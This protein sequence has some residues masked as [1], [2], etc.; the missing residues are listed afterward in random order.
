M[1][2][3]WETAK[4]IYFHFKLHE[5][6]ALG[7]QLTYYLIL[8]FFP[9]LIFLLT[10]L[11]YTPVTSDLVLSDLARLLPA[12][13][14]GAVK[15]VVG[16]TFQTSRPTLLSFSALLTL[17]AASNGMNAIIRGI[18]KAYNEEETRSFW[19]LRG[20]S[21]LFT[22]GLALT[23][24]FAFVLLV[25]GRLLG[26]MLFDFIGQP[27]AF[28]RGWTLFRFALPLLVML[29]VF[30]FFYRYAPNHPVSFRK[31]LPGAIFT[32]LG[33]VLTSW[34]FSFYVN[35]F[36][37]FTAIYGSLGGMIVL[38]LWLYLSSMIILIGGELNAGLQGDDS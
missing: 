10:V 26:Q 31:V 35:E 16:E 18:N 6:P 30:M 24:L 28:L 12:S 13:A 1:R 8:A 7:A 4:V 37:N 27:E 22:L 23:I 36:G 5:V 29:V 14:F 2:A 3:W 34:A 33:W 11:S 17:W 15:Q 21:I 32:S 25:L 9:F 20:I 19:K 38:L